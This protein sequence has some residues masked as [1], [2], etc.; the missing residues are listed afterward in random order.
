M[1]HKEPNE[2]EITEDLKE[3]NKHRRSK[4]EDTELATTGTVKK[5]EN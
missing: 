1:H 3:S 4:I 2:R 5:S